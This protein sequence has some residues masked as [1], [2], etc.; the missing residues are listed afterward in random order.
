MTNLPK[1]ALFAG[2]FLVSLLSIHASAQVA[3]F[4]NRQATSVAGRAILDPNSDGY[5]S[6]TTAGFG[7]NDVTNSEIPYKGIRAYSV[8]PFGDLRR[9]PNQGFSDFVPDSAGNGVYHNFSAAGQVMFRMRLGAI[10]PGSKGYSVLMDTDG[11]FGAT[12][13]NADPNYQPTTTGTNGNPGFEIEIVLETNFRI[14]IYNV[15]GTSSPVLVKQYTNWQEMSQVSLASTNDNGDPDYLIDFYI[16]FS[17]LQAPPFNL[18]AASPIRMSATTVMKPGAAIGGPRSDIYGTAGDSYDDFIIG[19]PPCAI[20]NTATVCAT[21]MCTAAPSVDAPLGTGTVNISGSWTKSALPGAAGSATI[22]VY[23]NGSAIGTVVNVSSGSTWTLNSISLVNGDIITAKALATAETMCLTSNAVIASTCNALNRPATPLLLCTAGSKGIEGTNLSTGW[24]VHVNNLT[25]SILDNNV[26]NATG[27]FTPLTGTSPNLAWQFSGGCSTG[28]PVSSGSYKIYYIN[29]TTGCASLPS[30]FCAAGNGGNALAGSLTV[31]V[32]TTPAN[33][34]FTTATTSVAGTTDANASLSLYINGANTQTVT[35]NAGGVFTFSNLNLLNGQQLYIAV[36]L[37]TGVVA[38]SKCANQTPLYTVSCFTAPPV[39][40]A[41]NNNQVTA[42]SPITGT[43]NAPTGTT[44][45]VYTSTNTLVATTTVQANGTWSTGN[46]GTTPTLFNAVAATSY[47]ANAQNGTCGVSSNSATYAAAGPTSAGRCGTIT[48]PVS[49]NATSVSGTLTGSFTTSTVNLYMDGELIGTA[50]TTNTAWGPITVNSTIFNMLYPN[51]V[52]T[53]G[54]QETAKQEVFCPASAVKVLC[55]PTPAAPLFT[56]ANITIDQYQSVTYTIS[57]AASGTF[58]AIADSSNGQSLGQGEWA[59]S[60]GTLTKTTNPFNT[61]GT[62]KVFIKSTSLSGVTQCN[63]V[64]SYGVVIVNAVVLP[65]TLSHFKGKKQLDKILLDWA[66]AS[67]TQA[68]RFEIERSA[69]GM[70]YE[71][72]GEVA[73]SVNSNTYKAY[74]FTDNHP[75]VTG[76]YYRLKMID[77]DGKFRYSNVVAF[78]GNNAVG[79]VAGN[80]SPN[81]FTDVVNVMLTLNN[82]S[83]VSLRIIDLAGRVMQTKNIQGKPGQNP[84]QLSGLSELT[85]GVYYLRINMA[86]SS[87]QQKIIKVSR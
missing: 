52:L 28:A 2:T 35:A 46:A 33:A 60:N 22:T 30:Y 66:T 38:T 68:S 6:A 87:L 75:L 31:P 55:T 15:D 41:D 84:V 43:S 64:S 82:T 86:G 26:T 18:T 45:R 16:P 13:A 32:I 51:A 17:D 61:P 79:L 59:I 44:I 36:E 63:S 19:Q 56:P 65:I 72:I 27:L 34:V 47:Y 81:P 57:N 74:N 12:G 53:I 78:A 4:I 62:Y 77:A 7:N 24:T 85:P 39:I 80:V 48:S 69:D 21:A 11:K 49:A 1:L 71:K 29:N 14:A 10:M 25:R 54:I 40:N 73:A 67:E 20:F 42:G 9:G 50:S 70:L 76:N 83:L 3:G 8:E 5:T 23:K 58:Y 37:N